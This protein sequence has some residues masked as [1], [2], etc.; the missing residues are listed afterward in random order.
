MTGREFLFKECDEK[1]WDE[2]LNDEG[3]SFASEYYEKN[4]YFSDYTD[5]VLEDLPSMY[6]F[7]DNWENYDKVAKKITNAYKKWKN[8]KNKKWWEFWK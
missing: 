3:N 5:I 8:H 1:F 4:I 6:H 7:E 2:D